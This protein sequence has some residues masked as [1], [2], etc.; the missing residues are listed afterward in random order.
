[1]IQDIVS[2]LLQREKDVLDEVLNAIDEDAKKERSDYRVA[3]AVGK[4]PV[5]KGPI[6]QARSDGFRVGNNA[7]RSII[8]SKRAALK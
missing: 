4:E 2:T 6:A 3:E 1:M 7:A 8:A 5:G